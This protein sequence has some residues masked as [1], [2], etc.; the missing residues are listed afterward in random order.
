M[1]SRNGQTFRS[2]PNRGITA[3]RK[4]NLIAE[5]VI[6]LICAYSWDSE[7]PRGFSF[8]LDDTDVTAGARAFEV[9]EVTFAPCDCLNQWPDFLWSVGDGEGEKN[10]YNALT[11]NI[12]CLISL[13]I[14][15]FF[16]FTVF[17]FV[18]CI[19]FLLLLLSK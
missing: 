12:F 2:I 19:V 7:E 3:L 9:P 8:S 11:R 14:F 10:K 16:L 6:S 4:L 13:E 18:K 5:A 15:F 17:L 1:F